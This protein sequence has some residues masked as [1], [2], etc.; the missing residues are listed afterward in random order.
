VP[1][2]FKF[3]TEDFRP[4]EI[5]NQYVSGVQEKEIVALLKAPSPVILEGSRGTGKSFLI[6]VAELQLWNS[7]A[8]DKVLPVY[9][10]FLRSSLIHTKDPDQFHHWMLAKLC[11]ATLKSLRKSGVAIPSAYP[12][13]ILAGGE[14]PQS[15][16]SLTRLESL[17]SEYELSY[18]DPEKAIERGNVPDVQSY[19]DAVEEICTTY[20]IQRVAVFFDEAIHIF[21]PEQQRQFFTLFRDLR[22]PYV[23]CNAAVYPGVTSFGPV[24]ELT[25]DATRH[26]I[27]RDV[28]TSDYIEQ[29][30]EI[31]LKQADESLKENIERN[32][33]NFSVLA[34]SASG[35]PR[36]LLKTLAQAG[37]LRSSDVSEAIKGFYRT[38]IW[39]EHTALATSYIGQRVFIDWGREFLEKTVLPETKSKNDRRIKEGMK[40]TT[41]TFW[42]HRDA[43]E[44]AKHGLRLLE[45]TGIV[46]KGD[47][48]IRGTRSELGTRYT[49]NLGCLLSLEPSP[50]ST[51]L[52][53]AKSLSIKRFT[54]FGANNSAYPSQKDR[55]VVLTEAESLTVLKAQ[56]AKSISEL[57]LTHFQFTSLIQAG[58]T[59][60]GLVL[61]AR[62]WELIQRL[63]YVG[64]KRARRI[65]NAANSAVLEYLSG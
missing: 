4:E 21:R 64:E 5:E 17:V 24:F 20:G 56:L 62:E 28:S 51:G 52:E 19:K 58:Y 13:N 27:V 38:G 2:E 6:R 49:L 9:L 8:S 54:E 25:H 53:I 37:R 35:N 26:R 55:D 29:M 11:V 7:F 36:I 16:D 23:N 65:K 1:D 15:P 41:C 61:K 14:V 43:P 3:R 22:S 45:Y 34:Y 10:S 59:S 40:E 31:A 18:Q 39:T 63:D 33:E 46:L 50:A 12:F 60:I 44:A 47:D 32:R 57:D 48:G 42:I 30:R